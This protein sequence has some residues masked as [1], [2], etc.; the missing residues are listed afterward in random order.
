MRLTDI[1]IRN[2][3]PPERGQKIYRDDTLKGFG[4]RCSSG[5]AKTYVLMHGANRQL[6]TLGRVGVI[7]LSDARDAARTILAERTLGKHQSR[8]IAYDDALKA[9]LEHSEQ[10]NR[11]RTVRDYKRLLNRHFR[12]GREQLADISQQEIMRRIYRLKD[13]PSVNGGAKRGHRAA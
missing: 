1:T 10:K 13:T 7:K 4:V 12:F 6:T 5:G 9:F 2:L 11:P 8:R 3:K